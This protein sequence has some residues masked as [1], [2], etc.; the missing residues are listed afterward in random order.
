[1]DLS[2]EFH[3]PEIRTVVPFVRERCRSTNA[4]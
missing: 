1:M 2:V 4:G 3:I